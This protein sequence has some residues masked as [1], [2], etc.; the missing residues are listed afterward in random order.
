MEWLLLLIVAV[1]GT[2]AWIELRRSRRP[3]I[4]TNDDA[5]E[6]GEVR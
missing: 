4:Y 2:W 6:N 3:R 5:D 1:V